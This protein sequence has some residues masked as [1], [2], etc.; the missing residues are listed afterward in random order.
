MA[1]SVLQNGKNYS[2][3]N[4]TPIVLG[5]PV[6]GTTEL[7][8]NYKVKDENHYGLGEEPTSYG[9][10]QKTYDGGSITVSFDEMQQILATAPGN[11]IINIPPSTI[12]VVFDGLGVLPTVHRLTNVRFTEDPFTVKSGDTIM[13][14]KIP[15]NF[16]GIDKSGV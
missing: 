6:L 8:Y 2:A 9:Q 7:T 5:I 1:V 14:C 16:A 10:G 12:T 11:S 4:V 3:S 13:Y 15:F